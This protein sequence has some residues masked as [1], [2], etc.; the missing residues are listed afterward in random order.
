MKLLKRMLL[1][2]FMGL[3]MDKFLEIKPGL[4]LKRIRN[5]L[6]NV[7]EDHILDKLTEKRIILQANLELFNASSLQNC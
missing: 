1:L 5:I 2:C 6:Y 3:M 4:S 7:Y